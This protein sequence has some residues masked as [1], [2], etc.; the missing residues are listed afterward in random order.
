[1]PIVLLHRGW[2]YS[3]PEFAVSKREVRNSQPGMLVTHRCTEDQLSQD[4]KC[5]SYKE[6]PESACVFRPW[7]FGFEISILP[8]R[9]GEHCQRTH[10]YEKELRQS[11][12]KDANLILK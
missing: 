2:V 6:W 11:C 1:M 3:R 9:T 7:A 12:V 10:Q 4:E 8:S 5:R